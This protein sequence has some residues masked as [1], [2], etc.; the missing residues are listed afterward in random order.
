MIVKIFSMEDC[1]KCG[2]AKKMMK[3]LEG[4]FKTEFHDIKT[5]DGLAE[6]MIFNVMDTPSL[7]ALD[8]NKRELKTWKGQLPTIEELRGIAETNA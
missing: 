5:I 3:D 2:A 6:A 1:P 4:E 8:D 7:V